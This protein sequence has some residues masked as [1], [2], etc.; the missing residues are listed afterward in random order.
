MGRINALQGLLAG[1]SVLIKDFADDIPSF[2]A[3]SLSPVCKFALSLY[4][5][6]FNFLSACVSLSLR[7]G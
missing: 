3:S 2:P 5:M 4:F 6:H 1:D 7:F